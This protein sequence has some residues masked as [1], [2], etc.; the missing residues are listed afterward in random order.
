MIEHPQSSNS[1][2]IVVDVQGR[3]ARLMHESE[4]MIQAQKTLVEACRVFGIPVVWT[5]QLPEKLGPTVEELQDPLQGL[6]PCAKSSFGCMGDA[7]LRAQIE[8][9]KRKQVLLCGIEAHICIWQTAAALIGDGY[10]VHLIADATSS[11]S[12][13]NRDIAFRRMERAG[14]HLSNVEMVLFELMADATHEKFR[15]VTKLLKQ[16]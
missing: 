6:T 1:V 12:V 7:K 10:S 15:E 4:A 16:A 14:V 5:E 9:S 2:L 3:L 8:S 11:R 13:F